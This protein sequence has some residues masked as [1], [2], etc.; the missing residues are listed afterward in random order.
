MNAFGK[1]GID[2][3]VECACCS[4]GVAFDARDLHQTAN[5]VAGHA[6]VMFQSHFGCI[7][8]TGQTTAEAVVSSGGRHGTCHPHFGLATGF[9]TGNGG[10]CLGD[11]TNETGGG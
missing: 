4:V 7:L 8:H 2:V 3:G 5:G 10:Q 6:E 9:G 11:V 1:G